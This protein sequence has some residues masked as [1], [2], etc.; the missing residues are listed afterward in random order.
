MSNLHRVYIESTFSISC[1]SNCLL[2]DITGCTIPSVWPH[3][4][5]RHSPIQGSFWF[6]AH[7]HSTSPIHHNS[8]FPSHLND[9]LVMDKATK[10]DLKE[11]PPA[12][13]H[14]IGDIVVWLLMLKISTATM[15]CFVPYFRLWSTLQSTL[16]QV[17]TIA[18]FI[19]HQQPFLFS[20]RTL[21]GFKCP[22]NW[23]ALSLNAFMFLFR[24][25]FYHCAF[26]FTEWWEWST[27]LH[28]WLLN[29]I[30]MDWWYF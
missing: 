29:R 20:L 30:N 21:H 24:V 18:S 7:T 14:R 23:V 1:A 27:K 11:I 19:S 12:Q 13:W 4:H 28:A 10:H 15:W 22:L 16:V 5:C 26:E 2:L 6:S 17:T 25:D 8:T 9:P 3:P